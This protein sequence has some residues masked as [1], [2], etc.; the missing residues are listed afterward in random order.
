MRAHVRRSRRV[1][2]VQ[3]E[4]ARFSYKRTI[5][6]DPADLMRQ[7]VAEGAPE[8]DHLHADQG[9]VT[10]F[11]RDRAR[12]WTELPA[13]GPLTADQRNPRRVAAIARLP[14]SNVI[15]VI[16]DTHVAQCTILGWPAFL[17]YGTEIAGGAITEN[18]FFHGCRRVGSHEEF[19]RGRV[20]WV[21][22]SD[23]PAEQRAETA[24]RAESRIGE[25]AYNLLWNNCEHFAN[26]CATGIAWSQ[27]VLVALRKI[28]GAVLLWLG[29]TLVWT[30]LTTLAS[31]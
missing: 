31:A 15:I 24:R 18:T 28:I 26:W 30:G 4:V 9:R 17:H 2:A 22:P 12:L 19:A 25:R 27:Q 13:V 10:R 29:G 8:L 7:W 14:N 20:T 3:A 16:G 21:R 23:V 5:Y 1:V 6:R 11:H